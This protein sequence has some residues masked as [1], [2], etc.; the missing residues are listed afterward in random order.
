MTEA[1]VIDVMRHYLE[2]RFPKKCSVCD[3][4]YANLKD[5]LLH[6]VHVGKPQSYDAELGVYR[7]REPIGTMSLANCA[8]GNTLVM[9]SSGMDLATLWRLMSW[10]TEEMWRRRET[11]PVILEDLR[12]AIDEATLKDPAAP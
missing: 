3:R 4:T 12:R 10:L 5:Y 9:D 7:P 2:G 11:A 1:E 8:C 6:T